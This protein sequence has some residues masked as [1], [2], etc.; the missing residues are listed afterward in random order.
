MALYDELV[1]SGINTSSAFTIAAA[2]AGGV[3]APT[4]A[5]TKDAL[6]RCGLDVNA[7]GILANRLLAAAAGGGGG[8]GGTGVTDGDKGDIVVSGT[9]A[10]WS[11]DPA[12]ATTAGR[13]IMA[14]A[15]AAAQRTALGLGTAA[16]AAVNNTLTSTSTTDALSAAQGKAL[17]DTA[18]TLATTVAAKLSPGTQ[19]T[20]TAVTN[21]TA[22]GTALLTAANA[23]AQKT[24]LAITQADVTS[25][26]PVALTGAATLTAAA[27]ANRQI[28]FTGAS[29]TLAIANDAAGGYAGDEE[30][31]VQTLAGSA[32]VP[33]LTTPDG[34]S[35][36][37]STTQPVGAKR[38]GVNSWDVYLLPQAAGGSGSAVANVFNPWALNQLAIPSFAN[39]TILNYGYGGAP[40][41]LGTVGGGTIGSTVA[42]QV[43]RLTYTG[44]SAANTAATIY[45][46]QSFLLGIANRQR[47][48]LIGGIGDALGAGNRFFMGIA[49]SYFGN[50]SQEPAGNFTGWK[51]GIGCSS[52]DTGNLR[53]ITAPESGS[54]TSVDLGA[55][56]PIPTAADQAIYRLE[57]DYFVAA[58]AGG[59]RFEWRLTELISGATASGSNSSVLPTDTATT[60][61]SAG[62][63]RGTAG[64][65]GAAVLT[66]YGIA[67]GLFTKWVV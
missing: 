27:H 16:T 53:F 56:F 43:P 2:I 36:I 20:Q 40:S 10:T 42:T 24:A 21:A 9:G 18:D 63:Q 59:R 48:V 46:S 13:A 25:N 33:T 12:V 45:T 5:Q 66:F 50:A 67:A 35:I 26:A 38:K 52:T 60:R 47:F 22:A 34:K 7:A 64:T 31:L 17:K 62:M 23:S 65:A 11:I 1:N 32:G 51:M 28:T 39:S 14:A 61:Y 58:D 55:S 3:D 15:S 8:G 57:I 44:A 41:T 54:G 37:G 4:E 49:G 30:I 29:A 19:L 6:V